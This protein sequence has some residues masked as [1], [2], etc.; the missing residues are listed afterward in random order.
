M[1]N[2]AL[3]PVRVHRGQTVGRGAV[4]L[5]R[6]VAA[7]DVRTTA[8][9]GHGVVPLLEEMITEAEEAVEAAI[10]V[11]RQDV[12]DTV[13]DT[14]GDLSLRHYVYGRRPCLVLH[15]VP[16]TPGWTLTWGVGA[17]RVPKRLMLVCA[18]RV[19]FL[20]DPRHLPDLTRA[21]EVWLWMSLIDKPCILS[22]RMYINRHSH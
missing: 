13:V 9:A 20:N 11:H 4:R 22:F 7:D 10:A 19:L 2:A 21:V 15:P 16:K 14:E 1:E 5:H 18:R 12:V 17:L 3:C 8:G 6:E